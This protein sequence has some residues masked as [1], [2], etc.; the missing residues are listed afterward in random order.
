MKIYEIE[1]KT[2]YN[3]I[4]ISANSLNDILEILNQPYVIE[5]NY[6]IVNESKYPKLRNCMEDNYGEKIFRKSRGNISNKYS[7]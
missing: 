1:I 3:V 5:Y 4:H 2:L 6:K 7:K